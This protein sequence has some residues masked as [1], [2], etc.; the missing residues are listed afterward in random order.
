MAP[1]LLDDELP[2]RVVRTVLVMDVFESVRLMQEAEDDF[3]RRW[4]RLEDQI[5]AHVKSWPNSRLI[6][7]LGDGLMYEFT[8]VRDAV[9]ASFA[10]P[11]YCKTANA[12]LPE[13]RHI[14]LRMGVHVGKLVA[15]GGDIYGHDVNVASRLMALA[16]PGALLASAEVVDHLTPS[17]D[18]E[19]EE[20]G[21]Y[22]L[23]HLEQPLRAYRVSA[24]GVRPVF[25]S[26]KIPTNLAPT[27][28][29]IA[30]TSRSGDRT[31]DA[32]GEVLADEIITHLSQTN[33]LNVISRL[34]TNAF[35]YRGSSPSD[36]G[37]YLKAGYA[38]SGAYRISGTQM[39]LNA[40]LTETKSGSVQWAASL[41]GEVG[42]VLVGADQVV[43]E[44][45][46]AVSIAIMAHELER[47]Q[48]N[49]LPT[50]ENY[51]ILMAAIAL[52]HR[53][54]PDDFKRSREMLLALAERVPRHPTPYAWLAKWHVLYVWQGWSP[55]P[56]LD[57][58]LA[59]DFTRRAL[60]ADPVHG[61]ALVVDGLV[62]TNLIKDLSVAEERYKAALEINPSDSLAHLLK[63]TMHAFRG[64]GR[65]AIAATQRAL[66]LSP[67]DPMSAYFHSLAATAAMS[68]GQYS[69][70]I[71]LASHSLRLNRRH[72]STLRALCIA[73][74]L[75][76]NPDAARQTAQELL[77]L[78]PNL[79]IRNWLERSPTSA[80]RTGVLWSEALRGAG[81]P[82]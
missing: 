9:Q 52:V 54:S 72:A 3:I 43:D 50:L 34:S 69:R 76:G 67:F 44:I 1:L 7:S 49:P 18:A 75:A 6:K 59:S 10:I 65:E 82:E 47:A 48:W 42:A 51:T 79:T 25:R 21:P 23:K 4:N 30:F 73:Q 5:R 12:G 53:L 39:L 37:R 56:K 64:E 77:E 70:A 22:F 36:L 31:Y 16:E 15:R 33:R 38:L 17:L 57:A 66:G 2:D 32:L 8:D 40:E 58:Q 13:S 41:K 63:G 74:W 20:L 29:V 80:Y 35:R 71:K 46:S 11:G 60:N 19:V 68:A 27:I 81:V 26:W 62:N 78:E 24:P 45:V 14:L 61:F 28:A 55:A